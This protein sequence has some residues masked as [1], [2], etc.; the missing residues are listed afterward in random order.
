[1]NSNKLEEE[2]AHYNYLED[3]KWQLELPTYKKTTSARVANRPKISVIIANYNNAPYLEK[4]LDSLVHQTIG[5][6]ALQLLFIDDKSTDNSA[7]IVEKYLQKYSSIEFYQL[8]ENTGG[9]HGPRNIGILNARGEYLVFLDADDWYDENAL[10]YMSEILDKSNDDMGFFGIAQSINGKLS[11]KSKAYIFDG[12]QTGRDIQELPTAF[13]EWLGPQ[14][15]ML[16]K[17]LVER[18]NLH[19]VN[20]RVADDVTFFYQALRTAKTISR[21]TELTTYLNRDADNISLSKSINRT[22]MISWFRSLGFIN[23]KFPDDSSKEKFLSRRIEWLIYDFLLRRDI[24]YRFSKK[25]IIDFKESFDKYIGELAF[26]PSKHFR[27]GARIVVWQYLIAD[28]YDAIV[29][30]NHWHSVRHLAKRYLGL[31]QK[32]DNR[33]YF[34]MI[35][36][37]VPKV[38]INMRAIAKDY[39]KNELFLEIYTHEKIKNFEMRN[40]K[41]PFERRQLTYQK[42]SECN[43]SLE[44]PEDFSVKNWEILII[45]SHYQEHRIEKLDKIMTKKEDKAS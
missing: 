42:Q 2:F 20:Q 43:Y 28:D 23:Q 19:F 35:N 34:P 37:S 45:S 5:L 18:N 4:M 15:I 27:T 17:D 16:R 24:G 13:Y 32:K 22:F 38:A 33:Y 44:I 14:G 3:T 36:P 10:Q 21:G 41:N 12:N 11:L 9:A 29:K 6:D 1:M 26:D 30:F 8:K 40:R 7:E 39:V 25:R 31:T